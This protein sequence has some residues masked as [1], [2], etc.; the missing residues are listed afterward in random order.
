MLCNQNMQ[1]LTD[2]V[3][4]KECW[5]AYAFNILTQFF[6]FS[7]QLFHLEKVL[8]CLLFEGD[9]SEK[10]YVLYTHENVDIF[11]HPLKHFEIHAVNSERQV[12]KCLAYHVD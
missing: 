1:I 10:V 8:M 12:L 2:R 7:W 4:G 3:N 9:G 5:F 6:S 11:G